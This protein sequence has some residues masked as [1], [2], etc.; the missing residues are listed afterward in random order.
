MKQYIVGFIFARGGSQG[1]P[2]KNIRLLA[3]KPLIAYAIE[4]A[5]QSQLIDRVVVS[6]DDKKIARVAQECGAEIPFVRPKELAQNN[7]P[8]W[9]AW[10]HAIRTLKEQD[11]GRDLDVFVSIPPTAPLR[12][13]EDLDNCIHSFLDNNVDV[14]ITV[15][16]A[17]RHPSFNMV[18]IDENGYTTLVLPPSES[19]SRRQDVSPVYDAT[20]VAYVANPQFIMGEKSIF[21]GKIKS[22]IIPEERAV[23]IDTEL[24]FQFAEYLV[25][26]RIKTNEEN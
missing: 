8:E 2:G 3:G 12:V 16:K 13:V 21:S 4:T 11:N 24:D 25:T 15:K 6:T 26:N 14:V 18:S 22:V 17:S 23:D 19:I 1:I 7:S 5:F 10:Q 20:T 9:L